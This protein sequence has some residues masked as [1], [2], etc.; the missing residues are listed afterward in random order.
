MSNNPSGYKELSAFF[1]NMKAT[2]GDDSVIREAG[3]RLGLSIGSLAQKAKR[4]FISA[5]TGQLMTPEQ[6]KL[7]LDNAKML[8]TSN[9]LNYKTASEGLKEQVDRLEKEKPGITK[10]IFGDSFIERQQPTSS[11]VS[12]T[13]R[14]RRKKDGKENNFP[15]YVAEQ[16]LK[17][18]EY[19]RVK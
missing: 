17:S 16:F 11:D 5:L 10:E 13:V 9:Y 3:M 14:L 4:A 1:A 6:R 15:S 7:L 18:G 12:A 19:E 8:E 2:Q